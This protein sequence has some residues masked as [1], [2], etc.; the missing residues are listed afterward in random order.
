MAEIPGVVPEEEAE[1]D[2]ESRP[3]R[4]WIVRASREE[5]A[6]RSRW[7][8]GLVSLRERLEEN[9]P[10]DFHDADT[11]GGKYVVVVF[12]DGLP[13]DADALLNDFSDGYNMHVKV[14]YLSGYSEVDLEGAIKRVEHLVYCDQYMGKRQHI[15]R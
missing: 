11:E 4:Q 13:E 15:R 10:D 6:W 9:Y 5:D 14:E 7:Q 2:E 8:E 3:P 1:V 12:R